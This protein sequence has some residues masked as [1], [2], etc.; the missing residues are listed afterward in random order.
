MVWTPRVA[1]PPIAS[2][3][4]PSNAATPLLHAAV[5]RSD[6]VN[7][8]SAAYAPYPLYP[9]MAAQ[10]VWI[11]TLSD[12]HAERSRLQYKYQTSASPVGQRTSN[13]RNDPAGQFSYTSESNIAKT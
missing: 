5:E 6:A 1:S 7:A 12:T 10:I 13:F 11:V 9:T 3:A 4:P 2:A 8:A